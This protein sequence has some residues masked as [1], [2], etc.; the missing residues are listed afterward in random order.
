MT[1]SP[2]RSATI[3]LRA[4][5][6]DPVTRPTKRTDRIRPESDRPDCSGRSA[7]G[8]HYQKPIPAD[9]FRF[10]SPKIRK[11]RTDQNISKLWPKFLYFGD[12]FPE[13]GEETQIPVM[14]PLDPMRFWMDLAIS[15]QIQWYFRQNLTG[16]GEIS[17]DL[18]EISSEFGKLSLESRFLYRS[19]VFFIVF[20]PCSQIYDSNRLARH[21]LVVWT[22]W[23]DY[24]NGLAAGA[25][26]SR[27]IPAGRF[28]VGHKPDSDRPVD[29]PN[30]THRLSLG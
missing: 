25:F 22:V 19:C 14:F 23:P 30:K 17:M 5:Q 2:K 20:L 21:S 3:R 12:S 9:R 6:I 1:L 28:R 26:F 4:V 11:T 29:N 27:P 13:S 10:S 24:S 15:H 18:K 7:A 8:L 16:F